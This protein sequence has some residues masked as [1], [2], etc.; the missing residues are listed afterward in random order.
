MESK[1]KDGG[2]CAPIYTVF[3]NSIN[4]HPPWMEGAGL[5][6]EFLANVVGEE[7]AL[8]FDPWFVSFFY[9]IPTFR[10]SLYLYG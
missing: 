6:L 1:T 3:L 8:A 2:G 10:F 9:Q 5:N 7:L 4:L